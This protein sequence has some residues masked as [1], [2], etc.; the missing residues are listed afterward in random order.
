MKT[1]SKP[2]KSSTSKEVEATTQQTTAS[3]PACVDN[4]PIPFVLPEGLSEN[5]RIVTLAN[6]ATTSPNRYLFCPSKGFYEFT[7][8]AAPK[9]LP[10]SWLFSPSQNGPVDVASVEGDC[11]KTSKDEDTGKPVPFSDGYVTSAPDLMI[12]THMDPLFLLLPVLAPSAKVKAPQKQMFLSLDDHLEK[13][14]DSSRHL[15]FLLNNV[16]AREI[17]EKRMAAVCDDVD[18]G[19]E[20][21]YRLSDEKLVQELL[22]KAKRMTDNGLPAS[23]EE[24]YVRLVLQI[25]VLSVKREDS[26]TS[27]EVSQA[28]NLID[29]EGTRTPSDTSAESQLST[30]SALSTETVAT[31][32]SISTAT[33]ASKTPLIEAPEGIP[34]LLRLKTAFSFILSSYVPCHLHP[35]LTSHLSSQKA[36]DFSPL[37]AHLAH[38]ASLREKAQALR[39]I[40]DNI[41]RKRAADD[42]DEAAALRAEKKLK[43]EEEERKKK[44]E[45]RGVRDLKK[46]NTAGM[47]KLSSFFTKA[48]AKK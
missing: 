20:Q 44:S 41:S 46:V 21:M 12:A 16:K 25:P 4:P 14:S 26:S 17:L 45:S 6:P 38:I 8:I 37:D 15:K 33:S 27:V 1:R 24:K 31:S 23:L 10:R 39:S 36:I 22:S 35:T 19:G 28:D 48:P 11:I 43:K 9:R 2:P 34:D 18:A 42:D 32:V 29:T 3:L 7:R 30:D 5:A 47:K 40:T 13:L